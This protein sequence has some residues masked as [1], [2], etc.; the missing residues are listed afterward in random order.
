MSRL[1]ALYNDSVKQQLKDELNCPNVMAVPRLTKIT[2]NMGV[3][4]ALG[5]KKQLEN[6]V[7]DM[8][9]IAGQKPVV[10]LARKSIAGFKVREGWPIGCKVTLRGER[11]WEFLDRLV[12][13]SIPRVRDFRGL[14]PKSFDGRGNYSM[15]VK[16]QIIFPEIEFDKVDKMRGM[17]I[18]ITTTA[19]NNDEGRALLAA[20]NFPF[21]K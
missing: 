17:D 6:A 10:C 16:E 2:L 1:K 5:D 18:T 7:A 4:E 21:R 12:D 8:T 14:N 20:L 11:M 9:A 19:K 3:G 15:G 13:I